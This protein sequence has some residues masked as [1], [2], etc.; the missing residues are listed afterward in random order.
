M[1][2]LMKHLNTFDKGFININRILLSVH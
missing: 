1:D 2:L